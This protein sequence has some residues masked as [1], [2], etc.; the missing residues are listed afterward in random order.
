MKTLHFHRVGRKVLKFYSKTL[1]DH[2][3][4]VGLL[5]AE[6]RQQNLSKF[7][8]MPSIYILSDSSRSKECL[9]LYLSSLWYL[10]PKTAFMF[11]LPLPKGIAAT[12][13]HRTSEL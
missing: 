2:Q 3:L 13:G 4:H 6:S 10:G 9:A 12:V 1:R 5:L 7:F 11:N 8:L